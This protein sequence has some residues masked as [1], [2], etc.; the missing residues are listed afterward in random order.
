MSTISTKQAA[1]HF[2]VSAKTI[3][4]WIQQGKL[5]A[6]QVDGRWVVRFLEHKAWRSK[7]RLDAHEGSHDA[8]EGSQEEHPQKLMARADSEIAHL[9]LQLARRDEQIEAL[10]NQMDHL[11]QLLAIAQKN[12]AQITDQLS[13]K[14]QMLSAQ[15]HRSW[16]KR[17]IRRS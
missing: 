12:V 11:M 6:E 5:P 13:A 1:T 17:L 4:R 14:R 16:W 10:T 15:R 3:R 9:R 7:N 8:H 2:G